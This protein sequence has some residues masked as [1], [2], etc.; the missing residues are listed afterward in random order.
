MEWMM[1][2]VR[3]SSSSSS[4]KHNTAGINKEKGR[5]WHNNRVWNLNGDEG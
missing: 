5:K 2:S 1:I 4:I 3:S